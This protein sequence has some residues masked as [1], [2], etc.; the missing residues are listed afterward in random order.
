MKKLFLLLLIFG[1]FT[2]PQVSFASEFFSSPE[3]QDANIGSSPAE[4][5]FQLH[6]TELSYIYNF[7][8]NIEIWP[9]DNIESIETIFHRTERNRPQ[10]Q[11]EWTDSSGNRHLVITEYMNITT[12]ITFG[13]ELP[14]FSYL[15]TPREEG[16]I[17]IRYKE[18]AALGHVNEEDL[19]K[20]VP[21]DIQDNSYGVPKMSF[22]YAKPAPLLVIPDTFITPIE[23]TPVI[24]PL[25]PI[26]EIPSIETPSIIEE[27]ETEI[28]PDESTP[29]E[30]GTAS[31][32]IGEDEVTEDE[33]TESVEISEG[34]I[35]EE[36]IDDENV[37]ES[38]VDT[39]ETTKNPQIS[40][41]DISQ[42]SDTNTITTNLLQNSMI[43]WALLGGVIIVLLL[44]LIFKKKS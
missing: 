12:D 7:E 4:I 43:P 36:H 19:D 2:I 15:I 21:L 38:I 11:T 23:A 26:E 9:A 10:T 1:I 3:T 14:V 32:E 27:P 35:I 17:S 41:K 31:E 22:I 20:I 5:K 30:D 18:G 39:S 34:E 24:I 6:N 42:T 8:V 29:D 25:T 13:R 16:T 28:I 33:I 44:V 37:S 40:N